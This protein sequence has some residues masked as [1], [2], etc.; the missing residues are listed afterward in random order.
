[1][2]FGQRMVTVL[3]KYKL[4]MQITEL[5]D[6]FPTLGHNFT[7][8]WF[9]RQPSLMTDVLLHRSH[10]EVIETFIGPVKKTGV[11]GERMT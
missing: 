3:M 1:M 8:V 5:N 7:G 11:E 4:I 9:P 2:E 10:W 6:T